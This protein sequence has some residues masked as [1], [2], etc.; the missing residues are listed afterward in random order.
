VDGHSTLNRTIRVGSTPTASTN[1][2]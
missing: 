2:N 1:F